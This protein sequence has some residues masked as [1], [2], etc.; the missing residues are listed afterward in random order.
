MSDQYSSKPRLIHVFLDLDDTLFR[1]RRK[2]VGEVGRAVAFKRDGTPASYMAPN[3]DIFF[4]WLGQA[5]RLIP[6]TARTTKELKRV[7][8]SFS[9][10]QI[11]ALGGVILN[12]DGHVDGKWSEL[13]AAQ[14]AALSTTPATM[15]HIL[16]R[17]SDST[18]LEVR[19]RSD[20]G[21]DLFLTVRHKQ[22][23]VQALREFKCKIQTNIPNDW[24]VHATS[25]DI[26]V[27]PVHLTKHRAQAWLQSERLEE[28][29]LTIGIGDRYDDAG[30]MA[31]CDFVIMPTTSELWAV[32]SS[33]AC[34]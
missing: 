25:S 24:C 14:M 7:K 18:A 19:M 30:F 16:K 15:G 32:V 33:H 5:G 28:A 9:D 34:R 22:R 26:V 27:R 23:D 21:R 20:D 10:F 11:C 1:S 2:C 4:K 29:G 8:L 12:P 31:A 13:V 17:L 6:N 3:S